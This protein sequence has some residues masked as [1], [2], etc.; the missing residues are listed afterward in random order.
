M[1][2]Y[3]IVLAVIRAV[4]VVEFIREFFNLITFGIGLSVLTASVADDPRTSGV[5]KNFMGARLGVEIID[6]FVPI[7]GSVLILVLSQRLAAAVV[8]MLPWSEAPPAAR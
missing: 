5:A 2:I 7:L 3:D 6:A 8:K 4:V 1:K